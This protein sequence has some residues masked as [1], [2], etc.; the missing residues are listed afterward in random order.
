MVPWQ[1]CNQICSLV[2]STKLSALQTK[3]SDTKKRLDETKSEKDRLQT[4]VHQ[5][6]GERE[7]LTEVKRRIEGEKN[8]LEKTV[9]EYRTESESILTDYTQAMAEL[10][11][12]KDEK[13][14][15]QQVFT[16]TTH[17]LN[18]QRERSRLLEVQRKEVQDKLSHM[19]AQVGRR[20]DRYVVYVYMCMRGKEWP[21]HLSDL[22][23]FF[24]SQQLKLYHEDFERERHAR[25]AAI[26]VKNLAEER[27]KKMERDMKE[28]RDRLN[29]QAAR[30]LREDQVGLAY[31]TTHYQILIW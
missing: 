22:I 4:T 23:I 7:Q 15:L 29:Q 18:Q 28:L 2:F 5:L 20:A 12:T 25:E 26:K 27:M 21:T 13:E 24:I 3:Y 10:R 9:K 30:R 1:N 17:D 6:E 14:N 11:Q 16:K 19:D 31:L 8:Q